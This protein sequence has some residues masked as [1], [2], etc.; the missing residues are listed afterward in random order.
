MEWAGM[1]SVVWKR[2]FD[3]G[4]PAAELGSSAE[5]LPMLP[6]VSAPPTANQYHRVSAQP[7][8]SRVLNPNQRRVPCVSDERKCAHCA[9]G[10]THIAPAKPP[11]ASKQSKCK[12]SSTG[13]SAGITQEQQATFDKE[14]CAKNEWSAWRALGKNIEKWMRVPFGI[15]KSL[16][17]GRSCPVLDTVAGPAGEEVERVDEGCPEPALGLFGRRGYASSGSESQRSNLCG[18]GGEMARKIASGN[19]EP[20]LAVLSRLASAGALQPGA[21]S[22]AALAHNNHAAA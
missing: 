2:L 1:S 12:A 9:S 20:C 8:Q 16:G 11:P 7:R 19:L 15:R 4:A 17:L 3:T 6:W 21:A 22:D 14:D 10:E 5:R 18:R 13:A